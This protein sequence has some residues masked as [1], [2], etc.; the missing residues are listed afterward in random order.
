MSSQ[1]RWKLTGCL[2][3]SLSPSEPEPEGKIEEAMKFLRLLARLFTPRRSFAYRALEEE[4]D[5][6]KSRSE[7]Q[8]L[9]IDGLHRL[10]LTT[11]RIRTV[12][13]NDKP[14]EP[15]TVSSGRPSRAE[16]NQKYQD[17]FAEEPDT[18]ATKRR[19]ASLEHGN[20][21]TSNS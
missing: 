10:L 1:D 2:R 6:W 20:P 17:K 21:A 12:E 9:E 7:R 19:L 16:I 14:P 15:A 13:Q 11:N 8:S 3:P 18:Q 5:Y 4:R